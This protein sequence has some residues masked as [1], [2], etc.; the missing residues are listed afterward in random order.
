MS[1]ILSHVVACWWHLLTSGKKQPHSHWHARSFAGIWPKQLPL[2]QWHHWSSTLRA[3]KRIS[4]ATMLR[5]CALQRHLGSA[6]VTCHLLWGRGW[7]TGSQ[8]AVQTRSLLM[9]TMVLLPPMQQRE[10]SELEEKTPMAKAK[11]DLPQPMTKSARANERQ[12]Q[13]S[14]SRF[15]LTD[16]IYRWC[17]SSILGLPRIC[18]RLLKDFEHSCG[19][20]TFDV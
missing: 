19:I 18:D 14:V 6:V 13:P 12:R 1:S 3:T 15:S 8:Q 5:P 10:E 9:Q 7:T 16:I 20:A 17:N 11:S 2:S 4:R